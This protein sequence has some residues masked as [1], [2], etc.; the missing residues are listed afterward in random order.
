MIG[1]KYLEKIWLNMTKYRLPVGSDIRRYRPDRDNRVGDSIWENF[2]TTKEVVYDQNELG[3]LNSA[4]LS[5]ES[6]VVLVSDPIFTHIQVYT[7]CLVQ[8][9]GV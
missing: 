2:V 5:E 9:A 4:G 8:H 7:K 3:L 1:S 6:Y